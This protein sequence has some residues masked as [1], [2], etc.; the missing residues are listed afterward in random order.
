MQILLN[1][2]VMEANESEQSKL[3]KARTLMGIVD[4]ESKWINESE[5]AADKDKRDIE[6]AQYRERALVR[7]EQHWLYTRVSNRHFSISRLFPFVGLYCRSRRSRK[8]F[9]EIIIVRNSSDI[10]KCCFSE[11]CTP[12]RCYLT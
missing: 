11:A 7:H 9:D 4:R 5:S 3:E 12:C 2:S 10:E 1:E 8:S 6:R